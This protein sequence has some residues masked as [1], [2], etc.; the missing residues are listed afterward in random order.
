[1]F[2]FSLLLIVHLLN[3]ISANTEI[4]NF[5][6]TSAEVS[7][8]PFTETW[9]VQIYQGPALSLTKQFIYIKAYLRTGKLNS[10][11]EY[12]VCSSGIYTFSVDMPQSA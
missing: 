11:M 8:L 5:L 6:A 9:L 10:A 2:L 7:E 1:M 4:I 3:G 12:D